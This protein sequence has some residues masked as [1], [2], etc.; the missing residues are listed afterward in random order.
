MQC[1]LRRALADNINLQ[2]V[3]LR[4]TDFTGTRISP[5]QYYSR[6]HSDLRTQFNLR[7][8]PVMGNGNCLFRALSHVIFGN[9]SE[10]NNVRVSLIDTFEQSWFCSCLL[11]YT[12]IQRVIDAA[13]S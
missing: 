8:V 10:H 13:T 3:P 6:V 12:R 4:P 7:L 1:E 11:W 5:T 9:E 2:H